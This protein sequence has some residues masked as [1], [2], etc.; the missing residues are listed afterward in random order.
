MYGTALAAANIPSGLGAFWA[1]EL[2]IP[3]IP[4]GTGGGAPVGYPPGSLYYLIN[5]GLCQV[6]VV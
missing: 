1:N 4:I 5:A 6:Y 3:N 2:V